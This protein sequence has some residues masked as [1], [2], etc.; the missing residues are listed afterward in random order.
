MK[1]FNM[2]KSS[3]EVERG[4][5]AGSGASSLRPNA[6]DGVSATIKGMCKSY[7]LIVHLVGIA[8]ALFT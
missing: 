8:S 7:R 2:S 3:T 5:E 4:E 6:P 1:R